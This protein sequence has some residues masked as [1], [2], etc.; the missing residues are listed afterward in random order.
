MS[1]AM[2][3]AIVEAVLDVCRKFDIKV[4]AEGIETPE[5]MEFLKSIDVRLFQ[6]YLFARPAFE[7]HPAIA[8]PA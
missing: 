2:K 1:K 5:E 3:Q 7:A 8:W 6:G 4:I